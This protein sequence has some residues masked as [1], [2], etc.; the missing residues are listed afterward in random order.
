MK[1]IYI[2]WV[3]A[4]C[5]PNWMTKEETT[6]WAEK[7]SWVIKEVGWLVKETKYYIHIASSWKVADDMTDE[8]FCNHH[9]IP[10]GWIVKRR[11][12]A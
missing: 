12:L 10:K 5:N 7:S 2:E 9:K 6:L 3:D 1:K 8:Q 4:I 11:F